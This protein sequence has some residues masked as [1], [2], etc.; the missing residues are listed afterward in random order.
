MRDVTKIKQRLMDSIAAFHE[1]V[2]KQ[3]Q[4]Q[5]PSEDQLI[6][7]KSFNAAEYLFVS[8]RVAKKYP[9]LKEAQ[10]IAQFS[11]PWPKQS[12]QHVTDVTKNYSRKFTALTRALSIVAVFMLTNLLSIPPTLQD[13]VIHM[14]T[15]AT[16]GYTVLLHI[17]L[18]GIFPLLAFGPF[19][20]ICVMIH[21]FIQ[22][23]KAA[24]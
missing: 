12:Y 13:M 19:L 21:F 18:F 20:V 11:T 5:F 15:T 2:R 8:T 16:I 17:E 22:S 4:V 3:N 6:E 10:I 9:D 23:Q 24:A 14:V 7:A 1:T